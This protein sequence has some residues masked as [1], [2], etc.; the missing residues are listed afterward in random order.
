LAVL[1]KSGHPSLV[2]SEEMEEPVYFDRGGKYAV[3][4]DPLDG[5][6]NI[7]T[8]VSIGTIFAIYRKKSSGPVDASDALRPGREIAAAGYALYGPSTVLVLTTGQGVHCFTLDPNV[9]EFFLSRA[10]IEC[11]SRGATFSVNVGNSP[12]WT[13][14]TRAWCA[15][16]QSNRP[17]EGLPYNHRYVGSLVADAHRT[18]MKGG[19]FA[20]PA[21]SRSPN[22]KLRLLYEANP[23][24]F[25]FEQAGG[26]AI[27]GEHRILDIVPRELHQ[28]TALVLGSSEDVAC[29]RAFHLGEK[30]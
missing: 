23:F 5:S 17:A 15:H 16:M 13:K 30:S 9:G 28:R 18:L 3:L 25:I 10:H 12:N 27:D 29:Y 24:A 11:P 21:D 1:E 4:F 8:N 6:S 14:E 2:A 20:Y 7:D 26:A 19:I 22:G